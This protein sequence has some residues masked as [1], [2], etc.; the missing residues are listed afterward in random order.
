MQGAHR[1]DI[2]LMEAYRRDGDPRCRDEVVR[3]HEGLVRSIARRYK[4]RG[5]AYEDI[6]QTGY[7][8]LIQAVDRYEPSRGVPL[9]A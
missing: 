3:R 6:V 4:G 5:L 8:G 9:R 1:S 2:E 7:I